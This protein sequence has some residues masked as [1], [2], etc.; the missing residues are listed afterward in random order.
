MWA[1]NSAVEC[2]LH[3]VEASG[4]IPLS[5]TME[6]RPA[7]SAKAQNLAKGRGCQQYQQHDHHQ[8]HPAAAT[9]LTLSP[10]IMQRAGGLAEMSAPMRAR[11]AGTVDPGT[12]DYPFLL[13]EDR[14]KD[15]AVPWN[16]V[17]A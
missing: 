11:L 10:G 6:S 16:P 3:T 13:L 9:L 14:R 2:H 17:T 15:H 1:I 12:H 7:P 4:S 8:Q 5:P